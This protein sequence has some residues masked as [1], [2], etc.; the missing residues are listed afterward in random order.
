MI[1][2]E[3]ERAGGSNPPFA[4]KRLK[5]KDMK[6]VFLISA[7]LGFLFQ[8]LFSQDSFSVLAYQSTKLTVLDLK[9]GEIEISPSEIIF[10][11]DSGKAT[12][13]A[14][15]NL[16]N[17]I[18]S[19]NAFV[20]TLSTGHIVR[21]IQAIDNYGRDCGISLNSSDPFLS[22]EYKDKIFFYDIIVLSERPWDYPEE[23]EPFEM[24]NTPITEE[25]IDSL[26][27]SAMKLWK[28]KK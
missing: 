3:L 2:M 27:K 6:K 28:P 16:R 4:S 12:I 13:G 14:Y 24:D 5:K 8:N 19:S 25:D 18:I 1:G 7:I 26:I 21:R 10:Q 11:F 9:T 23:L 17:F 15:G 22:I 20:D